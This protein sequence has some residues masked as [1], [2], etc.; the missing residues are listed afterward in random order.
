MPLCLT[1]RENFLR[2]LSASKK[3]RSER[4]NLWSLRREVGVRGKNDMRELRLE[5]H[6]T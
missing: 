3:H 6:E 5:C 4:G 1:E 2:I